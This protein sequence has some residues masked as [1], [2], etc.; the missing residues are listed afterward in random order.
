MW[1]FYSSQTHFSYIERI[2]LSKMIPKYLFRAYDPDTAGKT[3]ECIITLLAST[4]S[5]NVDKQDIF[6]LQQREVAMRLTHHM[7]W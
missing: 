3:I 1:L 2:C 5:Q 6:R 7:R 4:C